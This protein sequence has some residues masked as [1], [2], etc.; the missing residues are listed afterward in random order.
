[1]S[2]L[3][4]GEAVVLDLRL[5]KLPTRAMAFGLDL[6]V[7]LLAFLVLI[8]I[9]SGTLGTVD[10]ALAAAVSLVLVLAVFVGYPVTVE[11]LTRGRSVGKIALGLRVVREDGG[12]IRFRQALTRGLAGLIIDFGVF[13]LFTGVVALITSLA[14]PRGRRVGDML[15]GTMVLRERVPVRPVPVVP[16]PP[17]LAG[18][19]AGLELSGLP[20]SVALSAR[21]F[22]HRASD[23]EPSV[24]AS[25]GQRLATQVAGHVS[26][27]PPPG[28]P[29]EPYLAAVLAERRRREEARLAANRPV[30]TAPPAPAP[31]APPPPAP[32]RRGPSPWADP[33]PVQSS[34]A[35]A[36]PHRAPDGFAPPG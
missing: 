10:D 24:R 28:T 8:T 12:P 13:S 19:A 27:A 33:A 20:D 35:D 34:G 11:T 5:A 25:L 23:L 32:S 9:T 26:P 4:T 6:V 29:C 18:W 22:L 15:A 36:A 16:M 7:M 2:D 21:L 14:S 30:P 3:V 31:P 1:M 17:P